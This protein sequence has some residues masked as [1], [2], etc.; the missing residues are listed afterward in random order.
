MPAAGGQLVSQPAQPHDAHRPPRR[1]IGRIFLRGHCPARVE[2]SAGTIWRVTASNSAIVCSAAETAFAPGALRPPAR[3]PGWRQSSRYCRRR[4]RRERRPASSPG[5][6]D[7]FR[8][9]G[10]AADDE[11][12]GVANGVQ[13][14]RDVCRRRPRSAPRRRVD[15][16]RRDE[17]VT[18]MTITG[19]VPRR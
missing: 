3:R 7:L 18:L 13:Q 2:T 19:R 11:R 15:H 1:S 8:D 5:G 4:P 9:L 14:R 10:F 17:C 16:A 12:V 6:D